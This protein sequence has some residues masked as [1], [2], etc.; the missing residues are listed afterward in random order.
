MTPG[1]YRA[2]GEEDR[3]LMEEYSRSK[4]LMGAVEEHE[5][6]RKVARLQHKET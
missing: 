2:L 3:A 5:M 1:A 4:M 6:A